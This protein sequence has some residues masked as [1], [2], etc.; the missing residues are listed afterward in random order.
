ML[1]RTTLA[2][3]MLVGLSSALVRADVKTQE[4]TQIR[5][6]GALGSVVNLFGGRAAR[7]GIVSTVAL[8]GSRMLTMSGADS[9]EIIDL[10]EEKVYTLNLKDKSYTVITFAEMRK[11]MQEAMAKAE[12]DAAAAKPQPEQ[13]PQDGQPKKEYEVDFSIKPGTGARQIAG[14]DTTESIATIV[15][16]EKGKTLEEA[17]GLVVESHLWL[18]PSVP[19]L[20]EL[21]DFRMKYAQAVYGQL[22]AQAAPQLTQAL[23]MYPQMKDAMARMA[24]EGQKLSGT[25]LFTETIFQMAAPPGQASGD[26]SQAQSKPPPTTVGGL[27]GGL[28]RKRGGSGNAQAGAAPGTPGRATIMTTTGETLQIAPG[29]TDADVAL[30]AGLKLKQ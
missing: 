23:A 3:A 29:V 19:E 22:A 18:T 25:P 13:P 11:R 14:R 15:V 6:E 26:Q 4:R 7:E 28:M 16:R 30:P 21:A 20:K 17:G 5:F 12:K 9:G 10:A 2:I 24:E 27:V 1:K 8:K